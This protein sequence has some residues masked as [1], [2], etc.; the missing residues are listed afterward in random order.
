MKCPN[1]R[2]IMKH[3]TRI[4]ALEHVTDWH[5]CEKCG[6]KAHVQIPKKVL[7]E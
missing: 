6:T 2:H 4:I 5:I 1:C 7:E 3:D